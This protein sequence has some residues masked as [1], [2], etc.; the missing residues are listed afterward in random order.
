MVRS[1]Y[2]LHTAIVRTNSKI[3]D[4]IM[5][6]QEL[7]DAV[8]GD[9]DFWR[10]VAG[11]CMIAAMDIKD[12]DPETPN[13]ANR[14]LWAASVNENAKSMARKMV[15]RV[16]QDPT[17]AADVLTASDSQVQSVVNS[18]IDVYATG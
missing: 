12:E 16:V 15:K 8:V 1:G 2:A 10:Q 7:Y 18:L 5:A 4:L 3:G 11:A 6:L 14:L 9:N 13:H 17:I